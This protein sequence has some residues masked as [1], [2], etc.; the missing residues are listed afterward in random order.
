MNV[1]TPMR[2]NRFLSTLLLVACGTQQ[3]SEILSP[4]APPVGP[5]PDRYLPLAVGSAW[6]LHETNPQTGDSADETTTVEAYEAVG[7]THPGKMAF[8]VRV[9]KLVG[10]SVYW[11]GVEGGITVRYRNDDY[12]LLGARVDQVVNQP[13]R[14]KLDESPA[15]LAAGTAFTENFDETTT[16]A[17][18]STVKAQVDRWSVIATSEAVTVPMGTFENALHTRRIGNTSGTKTK[19]YWYVRGVGK[20]KEDGSDKQVEELRSYSAG[21]R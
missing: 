4:D 13:Y 8:R 15:R 10:V 5:L 12:D 17:S 19:D 2:M 9:E 16:D 18:G 1:E 21:P 20:V 11:E 6:V 3:P 7:P 14:L